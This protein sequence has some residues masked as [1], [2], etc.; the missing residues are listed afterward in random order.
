ME[1]H[2]TT[3]VGGAFAEP[4][5]RGA[6]HDTIRLEAAAEIPDRNTGKR[7]HHGGIWHGA[8]ANVH[9]RYGRV[10]D[11]SHRCRYLDRCQSQ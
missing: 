11:L 5:S 7:C 2:F 6:C 10:R 8:E 3:G 9:I 4:L 1:Q